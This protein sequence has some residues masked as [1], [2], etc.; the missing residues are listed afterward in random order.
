MR[1]SFFDIDGTLMSGFVIVSFP[2]FL[3]NGNLFGKHELDKLNALAESYFLGKISYRE[4]GLML[5]HYYAK[6]MEGKSVSDIKDECDDFAKE[7]KGGIYPFSAGL[8]R[9][10]KRTGPA[11]AISGSPIEPLTGLN[12]LFGFD[13]I[14]AT[15]LETNN[16]IYTG[17][18]ARNMII[19]EKK[20]EAIFR[21]AKERNIDLKESFGFG[22]TEQDVAILGNVGYPV[23]INPNKNLIEI[24]KERGWRF[25]KKDDDVV[26]EIRKVLDSEIS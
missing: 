19:K 14:L 8:I 7:Q 23:A 17:R 11:I 12:G 3:A 18:I 26:S 9:L 16:G 6:G 25:F 21:M 24:C 20:E 10:M 22:D 13:E 5:P 1:A 2:N 15:E 4:L